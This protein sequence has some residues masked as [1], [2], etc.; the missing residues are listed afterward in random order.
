MN[1]NKKKL[2]VEPK[3]LRKKFKIKI[4]KNKNSKCPNLGMDAEAMAL[5]GPEYQNQP[6][7]KI[8]IK[9]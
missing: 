1:Q 2:L 9:N 5:S 6:R 7:K 3:Q 4:N 8:K